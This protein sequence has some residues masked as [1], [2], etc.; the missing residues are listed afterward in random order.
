MNNPYITDA[1]FSETENHYPKYSRKYYDSPYD[2][3]PIDFLK[4]GFS[5]ISKISF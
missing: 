2:I 5:V 4:S 1:Y 3:R